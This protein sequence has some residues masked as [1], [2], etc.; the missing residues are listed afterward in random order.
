MELHIVLRS[1]QLSN[2]FQYNY[3]NSNPLLKLTVLA[4]SFSQQHL[5]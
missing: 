5:T 4:L 2:F 3:P 1:P